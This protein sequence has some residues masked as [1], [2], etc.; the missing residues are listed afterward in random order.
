MDYLFQVRLQHACA[1]L[2]TTDK[3]VTTIAH[4]VG[5]ADSRYFATRFQ[6][7]MGVTPSRFRLRRR[8]Q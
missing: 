6:R 3:P 4:D 5:F 2:Q 8:D 1:L 7:S